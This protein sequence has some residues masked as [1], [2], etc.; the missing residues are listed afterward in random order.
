MSGPVIDGGKGIVAVGIVARNGR[1]V[2]NQ[3]CVTV[4]HGLGI[5]E[6]FNTNLR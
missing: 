2:R 4:G 3:G 5:S 1:A 6:G